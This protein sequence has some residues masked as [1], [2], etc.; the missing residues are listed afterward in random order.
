MKTMSALSL[1]VTIAL[2]FWTPAA[3][4]QAVHLTTAMAS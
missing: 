1:A 3:M 4:G 2:A